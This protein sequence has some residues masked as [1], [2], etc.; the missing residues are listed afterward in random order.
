[1][2]ISRRARPRTAPERV[3][4]VTVPEGEDPEPGV[5]YHAPLYV[6]CGMDWLYLGDTPWQRT[7]DGPDVETGAGD[8]V[9]NGWPIAGQ[10]IYG[11]ATLTRGRVVEYTVGEDDSAEVIATYEKTGTQPPG[12][13]SEASRDAHEAG[14]G[15]PGHGRGSARAGRSRLRDRR[16]PAAR[17]A[18]F[19]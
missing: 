3:D 2:S 13:G 10:T 4:L 19:R 5:R 12:C 1:M 18:T 17:G 14:S 6:H 7:D 11:Y 15:R 8:D 16:R 9:P